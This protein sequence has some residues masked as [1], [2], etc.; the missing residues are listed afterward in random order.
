MKIAILSDIHGNLPAL[1]TVLA[2]IDAW[3]PDQV[4]VNGDVVNRGPKPE[5]CWQI[6]AQRIAQQGWVMT[7]GNHEQYTTSWDEP[8]DLNTIEE[9][10]FRSSYWTYQVMSR[11]SIA[12]L[13]ALPLTHS[14]TAHQTAIQFHHASARATYDGI[15]PWTTD[16]E[17]REKI[18]P[19]P[20]IF[21]TAHTHRMFTRA[22]DD[23]LI[24]NSGSVG[25]P[26]DGDPRTGYVQLAWDGAWQTELIR[27]DYDRAQTQ[28]DF[29]AV[30]YNEVNGPTSILLY[31]EWRDATSYVPAFFDQYVAELRAYRITSQEA[32][33]R[34]LSERSLI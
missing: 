15:G 5:A 25:C 26:L 24:I 14:I 21:C 22:I 16:Q 12:Q 11:Q 1:Q 4:V 29:D 2:H 20:D 8:S 31:L 13:K 3:H 34:F 27:L 10:L 7:M 28:C 30:N 9:E 18:T 23:T 6:I 33:D 32:I 17:I 19:A